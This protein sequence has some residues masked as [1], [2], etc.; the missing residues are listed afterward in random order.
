MVYLKLRDLPQLCQGAQ[1][2]PGLCVIHPFCM[3]SLRSK[4]TGGDEPHV[5]DAALHASS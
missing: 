2:S 3:K 4:T 1:A 5:Q